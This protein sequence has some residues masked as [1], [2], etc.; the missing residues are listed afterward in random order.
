MAAGDFSKFPH[1][2]PQHSR[3]PC[4]LCHKREAGKTRPK[5]SGH[6]PCAGCHVQQFADNSSPICTICHV[7]PSTGVVRSFPRLASFSTTFDHGRH[8]RLADCSSCHRP[9]R[10]GVGL[11][12][13]SG[14]NGHVTCFKCH[15][16]TTESGGKNIGSCGTCHTAGRPSRTSDW[17]KAFGASF[18]HDRHT[19]RGLAC[20][21]CHSVF[22]GRGRGRQVSSPVV[23][24][25]FP[26]KGTVSCGACHNNKRAFGT[27]DF[28]NCKRCHTDR[29]F[30]F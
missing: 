21:S 9:N 19:S 2:E 25:H 24:M 28:S 3:M 13:P 17:A 8:L 27:G 5:L 4:L 10:A 6:L 1:S 11:S 18:R 20:T 15:G 12:I 23:S 30:A 14:A 26:P 7:Q 16:P 22:A 29:T